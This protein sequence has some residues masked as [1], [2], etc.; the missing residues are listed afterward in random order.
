A[1]A[2]EQL[3]RILLHRQLVITDEIRQGEITQ[4]IEFT[5]QYQRKSLLAYQITKAKTT[6]STLSQV[7]EPTKLIVELRK[8]GNHWKRLLQ[9]TKERN[10]ETGIRILT[11]LQAKDSL[12]VLDIS[13]EHLRD[14]LQ[15]TMSTKKLRQSQLTHITSIMNAAIDLDDAY[16][17]AKFAARASRI[18]FELAQVKP[19]EALSDDLLRSLRFARTAIFHYRVL[20]DTKGAVQQL[21]HL[22]HLLGE[23]STTDPAPLEEALTGALNTSIGTLPLLDRPA[24]QALILKAAQRFD[25]VVGKLEK[26]LRKPEPLHNLAKLHMRF[27][28]TALS[29]LHAIGAEDSLIR[30]FRSNQICG[31]LRL[32]DAAPETEKAALIEQVVEEANALIP[33]SRPIAKI[34]DDELTIISKVSARLAQLPKATLSEPAKQLIETSHQINEQFYFQTKDPKVKAQLAL[35]LLLSKISPD[36]AG[37]IRTE[38]STKELDKLEEYASTGLIAHVK[39]KEPNP[40]LKAGSIL[41]WVILQRIN[42]TKTREDIEKLKEDARDFVDKTYSYMPPPDQLSEDGY[43]FAFLLLRSVNELVLNERPTDESQWEQ[44]LTQSEQ[45]AQALAK[46]ASAQGNI[47]HQILAMSAAGTATAKLATLSPSA[48][49][50][51]RLLKRATSQMQKALQVASAGASPKEVEAALAQYDHLLQ[52]QLISTPT[53]SAQALIF[54]EWDKTYLEAVTAIRKEGENEVANRLEAYRILNAKVPLAFSSL[55]QEAAAVDTVKRQVIDLL[56]EVIQIGSLQ[57]VSMAKQLERRWAFQLGEDSL[58]ASGYRLEDAETSFTLADEHFRISLQVEPQVSING[59]SLRKIRSFPFL[60][61]APQPNG[62]TWYDEN[63]VICSLYSDKKLH[64]W[65]TIQNPTEQKV[66]IGYWLIASEDVTVTL[67]FQILAI[68]TLS[69]DTAGVVV[70]LSGAK[71]SVAKQPVVAEHRENK[72]VLVYELHLTAGYP[73]PLPLDVTID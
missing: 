14:R 46:F 43:P 59:Q 58:L 25:G 35:Q 13:Q 3:L 32:I 55:Q 33:A 23:I 41:V 52:A 39:A 71:I 53:I 38:F 68:E 50:S 9:I 72:G 29:Q 54:N 24:D 73:E 12:K 4:L 61:P 7:E 69:Q 8:I 47:G 62:L 66:S 67:T 28:Q 17:A 36:T 42:L 20:D 45:F 22:V 18:W 60:R 26:L 19:G 16:L 65:L 2:I 30:E 49:Q 63:P 10:D 40:V 5:E 6:L 70:R 21:E 15:Q 37:T 31:L 1:P 44:L 27:Q 51:S 34:S 56:H 64:T 48:S 11:A 57:Q